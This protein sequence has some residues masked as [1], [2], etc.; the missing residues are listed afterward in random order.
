MTFLEFA[1]TLARVRAE[2]VNGPIDSPCFI[3]GIHCP[4]NDR[5]PYPP[6]QGLTVAHAECAVRQQLLH[7]A[8]KVI[9]SYSRK[10]PA[11][12]E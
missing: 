7:D 4:E 10:G 5:L 2:E 12:E 8:K 11:F 3:C 9:L 1:L 6:R